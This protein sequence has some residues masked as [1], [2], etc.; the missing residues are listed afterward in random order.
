MS[1]FLNTTWHPD[2]YYIRNTMIKKSVTN[3]H[4]PISFI[5]FNDL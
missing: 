3:A 5:K 2:T 1:I 4:N